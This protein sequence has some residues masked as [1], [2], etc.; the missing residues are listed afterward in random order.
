VSQREAVEQ[1]C[2][3]VGR[4]IDG[5]LEGVGSGLNYK[6]KPFVRLME[7]VE[8]GEISEIVIAH[9]EGLVRFGFEWFEKLCADQSDECGKP[10][11]RRGNDKRLALHH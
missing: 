7:R 9:K 10:V 5:K 4:A 2:L 8:R 1:F 11:A 6:R 3:A